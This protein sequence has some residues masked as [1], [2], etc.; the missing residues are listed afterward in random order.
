MDACSTRVVEPDARSTNEFGFIHYL[1]DFFSVCFG[2]GAAEHCEVLGEGEHNLSM[3]CALACYYTIAVV[4]LF[5][6]AEVVAT[7]GD[8][9]IIF[10]EAARVEKQLD[11]FTSCEFVLRVLF[12][13]TGLSA[14][15][16]C[17]LTDVLPTLNEGL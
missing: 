6:H 3:D 1:T 10:Y 7:M 2:E 13:D 12:I 14:T 8:E 5:V 15:H 9:L 4:F 17:F 11:A 16:Q